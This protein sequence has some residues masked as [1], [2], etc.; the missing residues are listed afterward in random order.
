MSNKECI[1]VLCDS[2]AGKDGISR[3][4][5]NLSWYFKN[6]LIITPNYRPDRVYEISS[7]ANILE[8]KLNY[9]IWK[10]A[11]IINK[12]NIS[13]LNPHGAYVTIRASII[14]LLLLNRK[15]RIS[16]FIYDKVDLFFSDNNIIRRNF[17]KLNLLLIRLFLKVGIIN[18]ILVLDDKMAQLVCKVL[19]TDRIRVIRIGVSPSLLKLSKSDELTPSEK[20]KKFVKKEPENKLFFH[21]ILI[22]RRRIE[23]LLTALSLLVKGGKSNICL[24]I[25]GSLHYDARYVTILHKIVNGLH[26]NESV[27]FL[28]DLSEEE[29]AYMY[30]ICDIFIFPGNNQTWGLA[31]L[32]AMAFKKPVI[33]STGCGVSEVLDKNVALLVPPKEPTSIRDAIVLLTDNKTLR[34]KLSR[35]AQDYVLSKL[36]FT[37]TANELKELWKIDN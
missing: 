28:G 17:Q 23:D 19:D 6:M 5:S 9:N 1:C 24:Y 2:L 21:G 12:E 11:R 16:A 26:L 15:L 30:R 33:V 7:D 8:I 4:I 36:I 22:P 32:E 34:E 27:H 37:N 13:V 20:L 18:E 25:G 29:L 14:K 10:V 3:V 35:N 31:P